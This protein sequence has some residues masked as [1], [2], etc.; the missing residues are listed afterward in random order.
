MGTKGTWRRP[1]AISEAEERV[2]W[3]RTFGVREHRTDVIAE[4][5]RIGAAA[6]ER[7]V[8]YLREIAPPARTE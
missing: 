7:T 2:A 5:E 4:A 3:E 6:G 1:A 8:R